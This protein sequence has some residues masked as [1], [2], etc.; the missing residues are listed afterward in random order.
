MCKS[1]RRFWMVSISMIVGGVLLYLPNTV[2]SQQGRSGPQ[3]QPAV[4]GQSDPKG[5]PAAKGASAPRG[6]AR[7]T[8][9]GTSSRPQGSGNRPNAPTSNPPP[10]RPQSGGQ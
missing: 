5:Q 7:P 2:Q 8:N 10:P 3:S 4:Q 1:H 9:Q 6:P